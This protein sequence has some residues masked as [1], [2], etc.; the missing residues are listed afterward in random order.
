MLTLLKRVANAG[1]KS[2][3][4]NG[5]LSAAT[6]FVMVITIFVITSI[7]LLKD[8]SDF[9]VADLQALFINL[10]HEIGLYPETGSGL[11][12]PDAVQHPF[13]GGKRGTG[14]GFAHLVE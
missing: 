13:K 14:P 11:G 6:I 8:I 3:F 12:G 1:Y 2:F 4:R 10:I 7:F 5:G 9:L